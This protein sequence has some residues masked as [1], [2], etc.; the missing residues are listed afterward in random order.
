MTT[1]Q[2][3]RTPSPPPPQ[4]HSQPAARPTHPDQ[5]VGNLTDELAKA[6]VADTVTD[7]VGGRS[8]GGAV[9]EDSQEHLPI[10]SASQ[11]SA[12]QEDNSTKQAHTSEPIISP[13]PAIPV[14]ASTPSA[15]LAEGVPGDR[16]A[17]VP[18]PTPTHPQTDQHPPEPVPAPQQLQS[19]EPS[20]EERLGQDEWLLK[21]IHWPPLPAPPSSQSGTIQPGPPIKVSEDAQQSFFDVVN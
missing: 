5:P 6:T 3:G 19:P 13:Q 10:S 21:T 12:Q 4:P 8:G 16:P 2:P 7:Q 11:D 14:P 1:P 20:A 17:P 9:A 18:G 15:R